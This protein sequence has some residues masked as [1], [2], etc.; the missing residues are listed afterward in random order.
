MSNKFE[1]LNRGTG[2]LKDPHDPK[3]YKHAEIFG[4]SKAPL[5]QEKSPE[6]WKRYGEIRDQFTSASCVGQTVALCIGI[7]NFREEGKFNHF[8]A[9]PNYAKGFVAPD[10]GMYPSVGFKYGS[11]F[12]VP[13]EIQMRSQ[14]IDEQSM[15][16]INDEKAG[17]LLVA[18][19]FRGGPYVEIDVTNVDAIC[20]VTDRNKGVGISIRFDGDLHPDN[21][22][23]SKSGKYGHEITVVDYCLFNGVKGLV[24]QNSWGVWGYKG[25]GFIPLTAFAKGCDSVFYF[26]DLA[27]KQQG[28]NDVL[29]AKPTYAFTKK[30]K[31]GA[32]NDEV[33][34][35]QRCLGYLVD[36]AGYL[37]PLFQAPTGY[38]GGITREA[39][40]R[41]QAMSNIAITGEVDGATLAQLNLIF[42]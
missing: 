17:D 28:E 20:S 31:L 30:M 3:N 16:L 9:R 14:L 8:S 5:W 22:N 29:Q 11:E 25:L 1:P 33:A 42:K 19:I 39:V 2:A 12:G 37:F 27:N 24:Y 38:F 41:F 40:K 10:G 15:R 6:Q 13:F 21:P 35:L 26:E 32:K 36:G 18:K 7:E 4:V 34:M 23:L